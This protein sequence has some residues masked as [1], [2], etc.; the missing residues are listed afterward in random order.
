MHT[1]STAVISA[2]VANQWTLFMTSLH[3]YSASEHTPTY[4]LLLFCE[5]CKLSGC[6][7]WKNKLY[8]CK[9]YRKYCSLIP[10]LSGK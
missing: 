4:T 3:V 10:F 5:D 1:L 8:V 9:R 7:H 6:F 2:V